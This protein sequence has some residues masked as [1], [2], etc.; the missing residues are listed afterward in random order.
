MPT[1]PLATPQR[2]AQQFVGVLDGQEARGVGVRCVRV[3]ALRQAAVRRLDLPRRRLATET[4][5]PVGIRDAL[6]GRT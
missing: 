4:E 1:I 5:D 6:H 2:I 3:I